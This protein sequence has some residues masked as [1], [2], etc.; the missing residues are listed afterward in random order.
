MRKNKQKENNMTRTFKPAALALAVLLALAACGKK[1]GANDTPPAQSAQEQTFAKPVE[2]QTPQGKVDM[3]L[4]D[5]TRLMEQEGA[6]VVNIRAAKQSES[7]SS[8]EDSPVPED[9]PFYD[10]FRR[11]VPNAPQLQDPDDDKNQNFGSG[12]I[13]SPDGY[14]L[15]NTHVVGGMNNIKVTLND[16][17]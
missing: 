14:I 1:D 12:F 6:A 9:D 15:T 11:L 4:P 16:K 3:L 10:F 13:I 5:F 8:G 7:K 17:R 2:A